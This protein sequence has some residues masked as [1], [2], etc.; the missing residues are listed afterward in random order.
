MSADSVERG[1][2]PA[3]GRVRERHEPP[4]TAG[5]GHIRPA[6]LTGIA[7][8]SDSKL[9]LAGLAGAVVGAIQMSS[10]VV[11]VA[12]T[13]DWLTVI[14]TLQLLF[15]GSLLVTGILALDQCGSESTTRTNIRSSASAKHLLARSVWVGPVRPGSA[16]PP[17]PGC[18]ARVPVNY[19]SA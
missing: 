12:S 13:E 3:G 6:Q 7:V 11:R 4:I 14:R 15:S 2:S 8:G 5:T 10:I 16:S 19:M 1:L 18:A 9:A 17:N